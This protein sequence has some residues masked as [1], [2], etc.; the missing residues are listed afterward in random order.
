MSEDE[1]KLL[2]VYDEATQMAFLSAY[3]RN[4]KRIGMSCMDVGITYNIFRAWVKNDPKFRDMLHVANE[5]YIAELKSVVF[6]AAKSGAD[7]RFTMEVIEKE[8][9]KWDQKFRVALAQRPFGGGTEFPA[10]EDVP[11][12]FGETGGV[13]TVSSAGGQVIPPKDGPK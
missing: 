6:K 11:D 13:E 3:I 2:H 4:D 1:T 7:P 8:D 5:E 12:P 9:L 10:L